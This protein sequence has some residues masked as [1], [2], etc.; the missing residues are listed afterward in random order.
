MRA[1][2]PPPPAAARRAR[3]I[4]A[5]RGGSAG[6]PRHRLACRHDTNAVL[7]LC[8]LCCLAPHTLCLPRRPSPP[9][10][11]AARAIARS[12]NARAAAAARPCAAAAAA[13]DPPRDRPPGTKA[14]R[15]D[16]QSKKSKHC[17]AAAS[18][19]QRRRRRRRRRRRQCRQCRRSAAA[20]SGRAAQ[21]AR[22]QRAAA[23]IAAES[24]A[25]G[26]LSFKH[27]KQR[28]SVTM[29]QLPSALLTLH[30][31]P[32]PCRRSP[33]IAPSWIPAAAC[34]T[35]P[36]RPPRTKRAP[37]ARPPLHLHHRPPI[38]SRDR[39]ALVA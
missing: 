13:R 16:G 38:P 6:D 20:A 30:C 22:R 36:R 23:A 7:H 27:T 17:T 33:D 9:L 8:A 5:D 18:H 10:P 19:P 15:G 4:G 25:G 21:T 1:R 29:R 37:S 12:R 14:V 26:E 2:A 35:R 32:S 28:R 11:A 3:G 39:A 34:A 31:P 24:S